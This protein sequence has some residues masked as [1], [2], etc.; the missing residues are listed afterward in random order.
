MKAREL[1]DLS[2]AELSEKLAGL[3]E[4]LFNLRFQ[5][6]MGQLSNPLRIRLVRRD[7][8]RAKTLIEQKKKPTAVSAA[9]NSVHYLPGAAAA[10]R[11]NC[12]SNSGKLPHE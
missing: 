6:K 5:Q 1:R 2:V 11:S 3:E 7:I 8:A 4:E 12:A 9:A 10:H